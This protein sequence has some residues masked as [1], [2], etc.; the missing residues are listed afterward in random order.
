MFQDGY[1]PA[2]IKTHPDGTLESS[3]LNENISKTNP[4]YSEKPKIQYSEYKNQTM[5]TDNLNV[6]P[7]KANVT[8]PLTVINSIE[9]K[10]NRE[11]KTNT[12]TKFHS[13]QY[14]K[15]HE[16]SIVQ[17]QLNDW[18]ENGTITRNK[19]VDL[20]KNNEPQKDYESR[21]LLKTSNVENQTREPDMQHQYKIPMKGPINDLSMAMISKVIDASGGSLECF[22]CSI[23]VPK[24]AIQSKCL[25]QLG[26]LE[27]S[28][29]PHKSDRILHYYNNQTGS[30]IMPVS[31]TIHIEP[32]EI[33]FAMPITIQL[34]TSVTLFDDDLNRRQT[35]DASLEKPEDIKTDQLCVKRGKL[36]TKDEWKTV[37]TEVFISSDSV[38]FKV[39]ELGSIGTFLKSK[40]EQEYLTKRFALF[41]FK[42]CDFRKHQF[43][44][45]MVCEDLPHVIQKGIQSIPKWLTYVNSSSNILLKEGKNLI[46]YIEP[47]N[48]ELCHVDANKLE[49]PWENLWHPESTIRKHLR[50]TLLKLDT[51]A[52][53]K[54]TLESGQIEFISKFAW[55][56]KLQKP[57]LFNFNSIPLDFYTG[58]NNENAGGNNGRLDS[59]MYK[60][61]TWNVETPPNKFV[62]NK[63]LLA[64]ASM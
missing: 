34:P 25:F 15:G 42:S 36:S 54:I 23:K 47:E 51:D 48:P 14:S 6:N 18:V 62:T 12:P 63:E 44:S 3:R 43:I 13:F 49:I 53:V 40:Y 29:V 10:P 7:S 41:M 20:V 32:A 39:F 56:L 11:L 21:V 30:T 17:I 61:V 8:V 58:S 4:T 38:L 19:S 55:K 50:V 64:Y 33:Q 5:Q 46:I 57:N 45:L 1:Y 52:S 27:A 26:I 37:E 31:P 59:E 2:S 9:A 28:H 60:K 22:A 24:N 35:H 16:K